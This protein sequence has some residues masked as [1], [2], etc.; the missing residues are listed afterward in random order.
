M[1]G[2]LTDLSNYDYNNLSDNG[3]HPLIIIRQIITDASNDLG[4]GNVKKKS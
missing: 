1:C 2:Q 3:I 4:E